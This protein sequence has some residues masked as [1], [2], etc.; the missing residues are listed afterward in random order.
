MERVK[1]T[2]SADTKEVNGETVRL[3]THTVTDGTVTV[4]GANPIKGFTAACIE[5]GY[6]PAWELIVKR[7]GTPCFLPWPLANWAAKG[8]A[9]K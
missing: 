8:G 5:A 9:K 3:L 7:N 2:I 1:A 4:S 6:D